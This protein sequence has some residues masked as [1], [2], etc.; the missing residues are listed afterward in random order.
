MT[1]RGGGLELL[2]FCTLSHYCTVIDVACSAS[3]AT[4]Y[5]THFFCESSSE[6]P[7]EHYFLTS[8]LC[9]CE[10]GAHPLPL[11]TVTVMSQCICS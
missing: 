7:L 1:S 9:N 8:V 3:C 4:T 5:I 11:A 6:E 10:R 2:P